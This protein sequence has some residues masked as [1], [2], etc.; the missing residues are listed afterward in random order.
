VELIH[1]VRV[2]DDIRAALDLEYRFTYRSAEDGDFIE[3]IRAAI[4]DKDRNPH[5][6][7]D[8]P[9]EVTRAEID[10]M[11]APLGDAALKL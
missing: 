7:H 2:A 10:H 9:E 3:G 11:L 5:W 4:I 1:R 6:Q 8:A